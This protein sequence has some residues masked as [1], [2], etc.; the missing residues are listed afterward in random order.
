MLGCRRLSAVLVVFLSLVG[1]TN[2]AQTSEPQLPS[3]T[4]EGSIVNKGVTGVTIRL[5]RVRSNP[6]A[7]STSIYLRLRHSQSS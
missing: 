1:R 7:P 5:E 2:S 6:L 4:V 3:A